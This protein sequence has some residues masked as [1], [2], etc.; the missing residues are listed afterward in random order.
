[1]LQGIY[2]IVNW[3]DGKA[4][5]YIGSS[6]DIERRW[7]QH[8]GILRRGTHDNSHLQRAWNKYGEDA[9]VFNVLEEVGT[10]M[11]LVMEQEYLDDCLDRGHCYNIAITAGPAGPLPDETKRKMMGNQNALGHK[12]TNEAKR[13][14]SQAAK[15]NQHSLGRKRTNEARRRMSE[16]GK[17]SR[18]TDETKRRIGEANAEPYPAFSHE[19]TGG[20]IP[21]GANLSRLCREQGLRQS[22]MSAVK[23]GKRHHHK[24]WALLKR[25]E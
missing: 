24:G 25:E 5:T 18:L 9:F 2:E 19:E 13:K 8:R 15:G 23:L 3:Q 16:A 22:N 7:K 11:L 1:M 10:D 6:V 20:I 21:A 14:M 17:G 4:S 12:H